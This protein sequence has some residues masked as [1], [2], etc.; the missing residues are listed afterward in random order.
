MNLNNMVFNFDP[1]NLESGIV[2]A[3]SKTDRNFYN[4]N[5]KTNVT[6]GQ[7]QAKILNNSQDPDKRFESFSN[8][9]TDAQIRNK[10]NNPP[11]DKLPFDITSAAKDTG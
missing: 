4:Q 6:S 1:R 11:K 2:Y 7:V 10:L 3:K 9:Y 8:I 5:K